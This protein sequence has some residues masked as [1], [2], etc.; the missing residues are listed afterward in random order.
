MRGIALPGGRELT[1]VPIARLSSMAG[2]HGDNA[3]HAAAARGCPIVRSAARPET[4]AA[5]YEIISRSNV[6][7]AT[8][9][10]A[11]VKG[12]L[13]EDEEE[14]VFTENYLPLKR[15][16]CQTERDHMTPRQQRGAVPASLVTG[17]VAG[18]VGR[19]WS[20]S[21]GQ[22]FYSVACPW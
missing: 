14:R 20:G 13:A 18:F 1:V 2:D 3:R 7:V 22:G 8:M 16:E 21:F 10:P 12:R 5:D 17:A 4:A 6:S 9:S 19:P 11:I 15:P